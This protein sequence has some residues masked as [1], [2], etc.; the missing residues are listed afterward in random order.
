[1]ELLVDELA[2]GIGRVALLHGAL[3]R[4]F[5]LQLHQGDGLAGVREIERHHVEL[6][7]ERWL[8]VTLPVEPFL[9]QLLLGRVDGLLLVRELARKLVDRLPL[10][11][12]KVGVERDEQR[13]RSRDEVA[14]AG[15]GIRRAAAAREAQSEQGKQTPEPAHYRTVRRTSSLLVEPERAPKA[16]SV[17]NFSSFKVEDGLACPFPVSEAS[18]CRIGASRWMSAYANHVTS[19][20]TSAAASASLNGLI[21][22]QG[23]AAGTRPCRR[24]GEKD[25]AAVP[26]D[27]KGQHASLPS[28]RE[29]EASSWP[30][31]DHEV[32]ARP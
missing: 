31:Q 20:G 25:V 18:A 3:E 26:L 19:A 22:D 23:A 6:W 30:P 13:D 4:G 11:G 7:T 8:E 29:R 9:R 17:P 16:T 28:R 2:R 12:A 24:V 27:A 21:L 1:V 10:G 14:G 15:A 5:V 32:E